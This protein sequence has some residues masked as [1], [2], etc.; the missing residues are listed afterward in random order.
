M[1]SI[2]TA[3][4][5]IPTLPATAT[6]AHGF[7]HI[8]SGSLLS[9]GQLCDH[10]CTATVFTSTAANV[11]HNK[12]I[13]IIPKGQSILKGTR[14]AHDQLWSMQLVPPTHPLPTPDPH[15]ALATIIQPSLPDC[16]SFYHAALFSPV[17]TTWLKAIKSN[18]LDAWPEL[19]AKQISK[20][21]R[22]TEATI[23]GHQHAKQSN[24]QYTKKFT[25]PTLPLT[26]AAAAAN[27]TNLPPPPSSKA[28]THTNQVF[29][30]IEEPIKPENLSV[31]PENATNMSGIIP[32]EIILIVN[33][34]SD[35]FVTVKSWLSIILRQL[36]I[37]ECLTI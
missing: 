28:T 9:V 23:K 8:A 24:I 37:L 18:N 10:Q 32:N 36:E 29:I 16:I 20:Y 11:Y 7:R 3:S 35:W 30:N 14:S 26:F 27:I 33:P 17:L 22:T 1:K 12:D 34:L 31:P 2:C 21:G 25:R 13:Q 4:L 5:P 15:Q 6:Q 19:S